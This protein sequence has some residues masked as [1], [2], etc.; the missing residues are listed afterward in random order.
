MQ[1][2]DQAIELTKSERNRVVV[3]HGLTSGEGGG[4][5]I[6]ADLVAEPGEDCLE[7]PGLG[8]ISSSE[9][10]PAATT[11]ASTAATS[12]SPAAARAT[13]VSLTRL[14]T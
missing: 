2:L 9:M 4:V 13:M 5:T 8:A 11:P 10:R 12:G 1:R 6:D 3:G 7:P 14:T